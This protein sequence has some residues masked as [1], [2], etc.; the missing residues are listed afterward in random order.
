MSFQ[1]SR[2]SFPRKITS[3]IRSNDLDCST[4]DDT[5]NDTGRH[6]LILKGLQTRYARLEVG[7]EQNVSTTST[8]SVR[9]RIA[10]LDA[11]VIAG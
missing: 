4:R 1:V 7:N 3:C 8:V 10:T 9:V 6:V 2:L 5:H 11:Y